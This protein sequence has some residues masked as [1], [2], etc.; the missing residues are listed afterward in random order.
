MKKKNNF[1]ICLILI[2]LVII[3]IVVVINYS[4]NQKHI[5]NLNNNFRPE[6][7]K[8]III[9]D[10]R[11]ELIENDRDTLNVPN[12][13]IFK[14]RSGARMYWLNKVAM[15][16]LRKQLD[17]KNKKYK[18][19]V[20]FNLGVNDLN[21][22]L[23]PN[24]IAKDYLKFYKRIIFENQDVNF[25][26]LSVNPIDEKTINNFFIN[27]KRTNKKIEEFNNYFMN[28]I[29]GFNNISYCDS[30]NTLNI[31]F[32]DGLHFDFETNKTILNYLINVCFKLNDFSKTK[33][34]N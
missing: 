33:A 15:P 16:W 13:I 3:N 18:Y 1:F 22:D 6:L 30:Y 8:I 17:N 25:Y 29:K 4:N 34:Y 31:N 20:L 26:F 11:M 12:N 10:S 14:A 7:T 27:Q 9:G 19:R 32:Y 5:I 24:I 21:S 28:N 23:E 2:S